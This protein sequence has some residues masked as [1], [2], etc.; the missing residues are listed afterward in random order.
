MQFNFFSKNGKILPITEAVIP[1]S[2]IEYTYGFGVYETL[3][4]S[5]KKALFVEDHIDRLIKSAEIISLSHTLT[6]EDIKKYIAEIIG[7]TTEETYNLKI[8]LIGAAMSEDA[9]IYIFCS[10]P[11]FPDKKLYK[12]G[13]STTTSHFERAYPQAKTLNMLQSYLSYREAKNKGCYDALLINKDGNITEGTR[14]NFLAVKGNTI[15]SPFEKDILLG[16]ARKYA[17]QVAQDNGFIVEEKNIQENSLHEYDGAFL[18][19]TSAKILPI[20]KI[21]NF[22]YKEIPESVTRLMRLFDERKG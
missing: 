21:G 17:L 5:N 7:H 8:L 16:V 4:V 15:Y 11:L 14:T 13:I 2:S 9:S 10:A 20:R 19:S 3:R 6:T 1:L 18:T 12:E 22:E